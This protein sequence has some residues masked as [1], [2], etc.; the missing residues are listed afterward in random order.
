M[1]GLAACT[2]IAAPLLDRDDAGWMQML[3]FV[4]VAIIIGIRGILQARKGNVR[5]TEVDEAEPAG[6]ANR[7]A[8][9]QGLPVR[10]RLEKWAWLK[11]SGRAGG[12]TAGR[13]HKPAMTTTRAVAQAG[14]PTAGV[15]KPLGFG[16]TPGFA[17]AE[18]PV[19]ELGEMP[20][21]AGEAQGLRP[22]GMS[23]HREELA[24]RHLP[25]LLLDYS[26]P[27]ALRRAILHYE[28]LGPPLSLRPSA[29]PVIGP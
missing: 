15:G 1:D 18:L 12:A 28:I 4:L 25:E 6:T 10:E 22:E 16:R 27:E 3:V 2:I 14:A 11:Q 29:G 24:G 13:G 5:K 8:E 21:F 20:D 7:A 26:D 23:G 17:Q 19:S 9:A